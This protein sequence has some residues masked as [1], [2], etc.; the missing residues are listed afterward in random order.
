MRLTGK[1]TVFSSF[2][3]R[4]TELEQF[5]LWDRLSIFD[6]PPYLE[7]VVLDTF[8]IISHN[9]PVDAF[10]SYGRFFARV[11]KKKAFYSKLL[12]FSWLHI[13]EPLH[14]K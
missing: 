11:F 2:I 4:Y 1:R 5:C 13:V 14:L 6:G 12:N 7:Q 3:F 8:S 10:S 9:I